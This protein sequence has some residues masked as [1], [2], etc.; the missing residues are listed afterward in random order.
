MKRDIIEA[1]IYTG[2]FAAVCAAIVLWFMS[3][4]RPVEGFSPDADWQGSG[5]T[6][7]VITPELGYYEQALEDGLGVVGYPGAL[8]VVPGEFARGFLAVAECE[9]GYN[10]QAVGALGELGILQVHPVHMQLV[11]RLGY[12]WEQMAEAAPNIVVAA[13]IWSYTE[14]WASWSC[15]YVVAQ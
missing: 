10:P 11:T 5:N 3:A 6:E 1:I 4:V 12:Y 14:S 2:M 13:W 7:T 9:S 15:G 8:L